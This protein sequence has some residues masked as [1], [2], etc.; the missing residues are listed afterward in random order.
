MTLGPARRLRCQVPS[1]TRAPP[2]FAEP[3]CSFC[4]HARKAMSIA[5]LEAMALGVPSVASSIPGNRRL[6]GDFNTDGWHPPT[7][8]KASHASSSSSG[9]ISTARLHMS[10]RRSI[11]VS[12]RNSRSRCRP[13]TLGCSEDISG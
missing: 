8:P 5:L 2:F 12:N 1:S 6:V 9:T 3:T 13:Q 11:A 7:T 10:P 4:P